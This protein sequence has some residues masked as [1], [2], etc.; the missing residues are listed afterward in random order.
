MGPNFSPRVPH[1]RST[2]RAL[3]A[4]QSP[5]HAARSPRQI[6]KYTLLLVPALLLSTSALFAQ[7]GVQV[8]PEAVTF[9]SLY[10]WYVIVAAATFL[11]QAFLIARLLIMQSRGRQAEIESARLTALAETEHKRL[12]EVVSNVPGIVWEARLDPITH[13]RHTTF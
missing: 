8:E 1:L 4:K 7:A 12:N 2:E 10:K 9:W 3:P 5:A 6:L 13:G 11:V